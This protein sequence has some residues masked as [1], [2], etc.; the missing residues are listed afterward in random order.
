[1]GREHIGDVVN[2]TPGIAVVR[3]S[4]PHAR[5]VVEIGERAAA[6]LENFPGIDE[7]WPRP[8]H[9][10]ALGKLRR[11]REIKR[12]H[13]DL[14]LLFDDTNDLVLHAKLGGVPIRLGIWRGV[15]YEELFCAYVPFVRKKHELRD[16]IRE[17]LEMM[18]CDV[19]GYR[20]RLFPS[21]ADRAAADAALRDLG[22]GP[23]I[24][25]H[26]GASE[27]KRRWPIEKWCALVDALHDRG[28]RVLLLEGPGDGALADAIQA[29]A[30]TMPSRIR[31]Q[32]TVLSFAS[33]TSGLDTLVCG[34]TGPM[35]LA[36]TMGT[37]VVALY[38]PAYP[39]HTGPW[40]EGH[41]L[42]QEPCPCPE[43]HPRHC[44]GACMEAHCPRKVADAVTETQALLP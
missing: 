33:L 6:V 7:V 22:E 29:G 12:A 36:A 10:G 8:T 11:V 3:K 30:G 24:G 14:A 2:T 15:K 34:D 41:R 4:F 38:G 13:F 40:G 39:E 17:L 23:W 26:P 21:E 42:L 25:V 19:S 20:P 27:P 43:R 5:V 18:G 31:S 35:H 9:Q 44:T 16:H 28:L 37:R 1:M 32:L